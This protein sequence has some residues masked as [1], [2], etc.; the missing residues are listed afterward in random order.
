MALRSLLVPLDGS[1]SGEHALPHALSLARWAG[2]RLELVHVRV[3]PAHFSSAD[4][5]LPPPPDEERRAT[6]QARAYLYDIARRVTAAAPTVAVAETLLEGGVA[7]ALCEHAGRSNTDLVVLT[8]HGHG[9][10]SR[11][12]LGS[13][14]SDLAQRSPAP[15]LLVR[16]TVGPPDLTTDVAPRRVLIA[17][18]GSPFAE[19]VVPP[20]VA[21]GGLTGAEYRLLR[22]VPPSSPVL[23]AGSATSVAAAGPWPTTSRPRRAAT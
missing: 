13:V 10:F 7:V 21:V 11:F 15:L 8:T 14:A 3:P 20:A 6:E 22:V 12:W 23:G 9:P 16:P 5:Y 18:D 17:I 4:I 1:P 2:A 19:Q